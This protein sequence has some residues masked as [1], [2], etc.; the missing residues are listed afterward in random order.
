M[1]RA[2]RTDRAPRAS[3][4]AVTALPDM[5][6]LPLPYE[7]PS[8]EDDEY[9]SDEEEEEEEEAVIEGVKTSEHY[10]HAV[11]DEEPDAVEVADLQLS[12][13]PGLS[14]LRIRPPMECVRIAREFDYSNQ[15][16][17]EL[18]RFLWAGALDLASKFFWT[19][20][21]VRAR[22]SPA[23]ASP[24]CRSR[25]RASPARASRARAPRPRARLAHAMDALGRCVC[26]ARYSLCFANNIFS[27]CLILMTHTN[28]SRKLKRNKL[29]AAAQPCARSL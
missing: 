19:G 20:A 4:Q 15:Q 22:A 12:A 27:R 17:I 8:G 6:P 23:G 10:E 16:L 26:F 18:L 5:E 21:R 25:T 9:R 14:R 24:A 11:A 1:G 13:M 28:A 2:D 7:V 3:P 29:R